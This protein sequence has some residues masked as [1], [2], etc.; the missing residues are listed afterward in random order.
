[1]A[2]GENKGL[3]SGQFGMLDYVGLAFAGGF[4]ILAAALADFFMKPNSS[5]LYVFNHWMYEVAQTLA[6]PTPPIYAVLL[7]LA[8]I[9]AG[10]IFYF[11]PVT[12]QGAFAQGFGLLAAL[13]TISPADNDVSADA[14]ADPVEQAIYLE[15][16]S[17]ADRTPLEHGEVE[18]RLAAMRAQSIAAARVER[19]STVAVVAQRYDV[20]FKVRMPNG[21][22]DRLVDNARQGVARARVYNSE[23]RRAYNILGPNARLDDDDPNVLVLPVG[24]P[25]GDGEAS[26]EIKVRFEIP[27]Y[28]ILEASKTMQVGE[29]EDWVLELKPSNVPLRLQRLGRA[30]SF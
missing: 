4:G 27:G 7:I 23:T 11:Q 25:A 17:L 21:V 16:I 13:V 1:M 14:L 30:F 5:S 2:Y 22:P 29:R 15:E 8:G 20:I 10:S 12:R 9:G 6:L 26:A 3:V 28:E 24:V 18:Q 19:A